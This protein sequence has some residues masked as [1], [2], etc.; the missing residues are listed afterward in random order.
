MANEYRT[1][2]SA[3][4]ILGKELEK[5]RVAKGL[6]RMQLGRKIKVTDQQVARYE[7]GDFVPMSVL[8]SIAEALGEPIQKRIIRRISILRKIEME[9]QEEPEELAALYQEMFVVDPY[10]D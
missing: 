5:L 8:E 10:E 7:A 4:I 2:K 9:M 6:T 3:E 1:G